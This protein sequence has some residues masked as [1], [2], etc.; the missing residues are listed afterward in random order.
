MKYTT[1]TKKVENKYNILEDKIT[2]NDNATKESVKRLENQ[3][4]SL[5]EAEE[6]RQRRERRN[7][8]IIKSKDLN[9]DPPS[10][11]NTKVKNILQKMDYTGEYKKATYIGKD[12]LNNGIVRVELGKMED[13][14]N[15][16]KK[17]INLK[18][19][20]CYVDSDLRDKKE[21]YSKK[22]EREREKKEREATL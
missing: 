5:E 4:K 17:K 13:K 15:I 12:R 14:I 18:G 10:E 9:G 6:G 20:D 19:D 2:N 7:N 8:I 21:K 22:S 3:I 16:L 1:W 11:I